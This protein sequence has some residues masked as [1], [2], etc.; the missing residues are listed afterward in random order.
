MRRADL[1]IEKLR[2]VIEALQKGQPINVEKVLG[3][4]DEAQE[5]DWEA[6]LKEIEMEDQ[7][8]Q[9]NKKRRR[10][11]KAK[12]EAEKEG[13]S[14]INETIDKLVNVTDHASIEHQ[15]ARPALGFY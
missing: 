2:R 9:S 5:L 14:P 8:W 3:T 7:L 12:E 13:A 1:Q 10:E 15:P 4:G 11:A 6:A